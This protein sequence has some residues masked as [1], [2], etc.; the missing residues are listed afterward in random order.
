MSTWNGVA[1]TVGDSG[2]SGIIIS[3]NTI[4]NSR[5]GIV[6][7]SHATATITNNIIYNTKGGIMNYTAD[8]ADANNRMMT[9]NSWGTSHNEW[10]IVWNTFAYYTPDYHTSVLVL[11]VANNGAYVLDRRGPD[12]ATCAALT[13][14]RSHVW[15]NTLTGTLTK[16]PA[17]GNMNLPYGTIALGEEAV[18]AGG[19]LY[20]YPEPV[21]PF[22]SS[23]YGNIYTSAGSPAVGQKVDAFIDTIGKIASA[24]IF[25]DA[26]LLTYRIDVPGDLD[27]TTA[28]EGGAEGDLITF[29]INGVVVGTGYWHSETNVELNFAG[30][31]LSDLSQV[32]NGTARHATVTINP[33]TPTLAYTVTY[34][35]SASEPIDAGIT[36]LLPPSPRRT[37]KVPLLTTCI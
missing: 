26:G 2:S 19:T 35:G 24:T 12:A 20:I 1:I 36:R 18:I 27:V 5:N 33:T 11:S 9:G 14:N 7:R 17:N 22:P 32:Y 29:K 34:D 25:S 37:I 15:V 28:K 30:V 21:P 8:Q 31:T 16:H 6:I 3:G 23:F 13:H 4:Y 10:D